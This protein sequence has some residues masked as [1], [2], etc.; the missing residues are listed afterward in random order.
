MNLAFKH[1]VTK[2][3]SESAASHLEDLSKIHEQ[4]ELEVEN[5]REEKKA[6][7]CKKCCSVICCWVANKKKVSFVMKNTT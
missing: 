2:Y 3:I 7:R 4:S 6:S 5:E 1:F